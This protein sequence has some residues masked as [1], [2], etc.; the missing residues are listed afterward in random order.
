MCKRSPPPV[1]WRRAWLTAGVAVALLAAAIGCGPA[2]AGSCEKEIAGAAQRYGV[3]LAVFYAVGLNETGGPN[4][5]QPYAMN[6]DGRPS[7]NPTLQDGLAAF[8]AAR[9]NGARLIDVG[10][11]QINYKYHGAKFA[12]VAEMFDPAHNIDYAARFL[13]ELR[14]REGSWTLAVARY[15]AGPD[16]NPAQKKYVCDVIGRMV[17]SGFGAWTAN[18]RSFCGVAEPSP[19]VSAAPA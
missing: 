6:I 19:K 4:G 18:A 3:P 7:A 17:K 9:R 10:C 2:R 12:S 14:A 1:G 5:L 13:K 11:M 8:A 16:N 15:N